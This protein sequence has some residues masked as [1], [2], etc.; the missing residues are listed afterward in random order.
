MDLVTIDHLLTTTRSVRK[1]L[2]L[3][4]AVDLHVIQH[5]IEIAIQAP[6]GG[7]RGL[8]H[9]RAAPQGYFRP[10]LLRY[11]GNEAQLGLLFR[12]REQVASL[13]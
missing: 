1:R 8:Y 3:R 9:C 12:R 7:N 2:D 11:L 10:Y 5:C 4:H 13:P 6:N